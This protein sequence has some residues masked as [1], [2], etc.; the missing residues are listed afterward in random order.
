MHALSNTFLRLSVVAAVV[1]MVWGN[2]MG[3][4]HDHTTAS[5]HA[6]LNLLGWVSMALYGLVYRALP[7]AAAGRLPE[8]HLW[9]SIA[10]LVVM[11]PALAVVLSAYQ[12]L[13][14]LAAPLLALTGLTMLVS[15]IVFAV[16][17]FRATGGKVAA[18]AN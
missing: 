4:S 8:A 3:A 18:V 11:V 1:R 2:V 7:Q 14:G 6:H 9:L 10:S 16:I 12:P 17:I 15:M 5:A 13:I